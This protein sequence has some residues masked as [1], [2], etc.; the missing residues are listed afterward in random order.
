MT[1]YEEYQTSYLVLVKL[2]GDTSRGRIVNAAG[3]VKDAIDRIT[4]AKNKLFFSSGDGC[5]FAFFVET[6]MRADTVRAT[7][8]GE[9]KVVHTSPLSNDDSVLVLEAGKDWAA[10]GFSNS[11]HWLQHH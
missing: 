1:L 5:S 7:L 2:G 8:R 6:K 4:D 11:W 10:W 9:T 3:A